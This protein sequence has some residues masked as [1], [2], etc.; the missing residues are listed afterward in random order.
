MQKMTGMPAQRLRL[1]DRGILRPGNAADL[2]VFD[3]ATVKDEATFGDPH[4]YPAGIPYVIVNGSVV[5][6]DGTFTAA[7][8]GRVLTPPA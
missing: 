6:D 8:T 5:V 1:G 3:P 2:S 4:H 7:G